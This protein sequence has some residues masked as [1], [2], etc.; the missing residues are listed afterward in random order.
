MLFGCSGNEKADKP[1]EEPRIVIGEESEQSYGIKVNNATGKE[2]VSFA[3]E[4]P[5]GVRGLEVADLAI[6]NDEKIVIHVTESNFTA[7]D[8]K[9]ETAAEA[10]A[11]EDSDN[12]DVAIRTLYNVIVGFS[13]QTSAT[14]HALGAEEVDEYT[15]KLS[16]DGVLFVEYTNANGETE[17]T[18]ETEKALIEA[19]EAA[20]RAQEEAAAAEAQAAAEAAANA[21]AYTYDYSYSYGNSGS[22]G[23]GG[24][25]GQSEDQCVE[26]GVALR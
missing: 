17:S 22:S 23:S 15:L 3:V 10:V 4:T 19:A 26:G 8:T 25:V 2:I 12:R 18:L 16:E 9:T 13:D 7:V 5:E 21:T 24:S 14:A 20:A 11:E 6:A 1:A